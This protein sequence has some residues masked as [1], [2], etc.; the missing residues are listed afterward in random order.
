MVNLLS[1]HKI[2]NDDSQH[3]VPSISSISNLNVP[4]ESAFAPKI[5][6]CLESVDSCPHSSHKIKKLL[7][8]ISLFIVLFETTMASCFLSMCHRSKKKPRGARQCHK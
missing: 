7:G 5:I 4:F 3:F 1:L 2:E 8:R 6:W